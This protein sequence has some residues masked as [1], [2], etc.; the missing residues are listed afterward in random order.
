GIF[1]LSLHR[2]DAFRISGRTAPSAR[3][4][5]GTEII[6]L[7]K[8]FLRQDLRADPDIDLRQYRRPYTVKIGV[9]DGHSMTIE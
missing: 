2:N 6:R 3:A 1:I 5:H 9:S 7:R 4:V 8:I